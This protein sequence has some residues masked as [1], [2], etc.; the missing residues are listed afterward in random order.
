MTIS[1]D[2][3]ARTITTSMPDYIPN[4]LARHPPPT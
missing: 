3:A 1:H 2:R 4:L